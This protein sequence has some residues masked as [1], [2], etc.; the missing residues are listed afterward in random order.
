MQNAKWQNRSAETNIFYKNVSFGNALCKDQSIGRAPHDRRLPGL[1]YA[2][3]GVERKQ[4][5]KQQSMKD[6][7]H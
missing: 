3:E 6:I 2:R 1:C 5:E 7:F 4:T